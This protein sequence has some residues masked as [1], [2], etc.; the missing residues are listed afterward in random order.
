MRCPGIYILARVL[1][2]AAAA[3][4]PASLAPSHAAAAPH[5]ISFIL[6]VNDTWMGNSTPPSTCFAYVVTPLLPANETFKNASHQQVGTCDQGPLIWNATDRGLLVQFMSSNIMDASPPACYIPYINATER[7]GY[8][9]PAHLGDAP[10][11]MTCSVA[12][13]REGY[14]MTFYWFS[15]LSWVFGDG[16]G[17]SNSCITG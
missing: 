11:L 1:A 14:H 4:S 15:V 9:L 16:C 8:I 3:A 5:S 10:Q 7:L 12:D 6:T 13:S 17:D 2:A